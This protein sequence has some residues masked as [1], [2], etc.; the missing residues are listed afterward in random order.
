[1]KFVI[2]KDIEEIAEYIASVINRELSSGKCVLWFLSGGSSVP[3]EVLASKKITAKHQDKLFVVLGDERYGE[4]LHTES[5]CLNLV[6]SGFSIP[7]ANIVPVLIGKSF[8]YTAKYL[9]DTLTE[10]FKRADYK[11]GVFG[12]GIDGHTSGILPHSEAVHVNELVCAYETHQYNRITLTPKAIEMI[13][14]AVVY[15]VG[16]NKWP[17]LEMLKQDISIENEPAQVLKKVPI[18][19]IFTDYNK[20]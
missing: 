5:N 10:L 9:N 8:L 13:D 2:N 7:A 16:E 12:I 20:F 17:V 11:I 18:L 4:I 19:T 6:K 3:I 1:M 15:A 14:E